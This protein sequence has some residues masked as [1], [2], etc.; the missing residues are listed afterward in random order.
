MAREMYL[1]GVSEE[2]LQPPPKPEAPKTP[3]GKWEN[4]WYHY[5][6]HTIAAAAVVVVLSVLIMQMVNKDDPDYT[7]E[8][9]TKAAYPE[10]TIQQLEKELA[11]Y[12]RDLDKDGKVEVQIDNIYIDSTN[13][14]YS[15]VNLQ[16]L[17][18]HL[19]AGDVLFY[20]LEPDCY[21]D[22]IKIHETEGYTFFTPLTVDNV[23]VSQDK[24]YWNWKNDTIRKDEVLSALPENL[25]FGVRQATGTASS[26]D[27]K[28]LNSESVALL[29]AFI[30]KT[31][32][33]PVQQ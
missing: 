22:Y 31:P 15:S 24:L 32:L 7:L 11:I 4:F 14:Q 25:Y 30:A 28:Q 10:S 23:G 19:A 18:V 33:E 3:K 12:G 6:W 20:V 16:K 13:S 21:T 1:V 2:E 29:E 9:V 17:S 27:A 8:L 5:K 26:K